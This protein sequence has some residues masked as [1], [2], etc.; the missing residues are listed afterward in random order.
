MED[1]AFLYSP[2]WGFLPVAY[3]G[4]ISQDPGRTFKEFIASGGTRSITY[5]PVSSKTWEVRGTVPWDWAQVIQ[6]VLDG[7]Y[8]YGPFWWIPPLAKQF[9]ALPSTFLGNKTGAPFTDK[10]GVVIPCSPATGT[11]LGVTTPVYPGMDFV[12]SSWM[13]AGI[14]RVAFMDSAGT[15]ISSNQ[16]THLGSE[17]ER[18]SLAGKAPSDARLV[19]VEV[20]NAAWTGQPALTWTK[21][22]TPYG[23]PGA[24]SQAFIS[25]DNFSHGRLGVNPDDTEVEVS[26]RIMEVGNNAGQL[27]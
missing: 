9:N 7:N 8:G 1:A 25:G 23:P 11:T 19:R 6:L 12:A 2:T 14:F 15:D 27:G 16:F 21:E 5:R 24:C 17:L 13:T 22:L 10:S 3:D 26:Y 4:S 20:S 18:V